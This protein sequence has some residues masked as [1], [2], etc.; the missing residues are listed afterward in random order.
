[1]DSGIITT[2]IPADETVVLMIV[3]GIVGALAMVYKTYKHLTLKKLIPM[4]I[5][6]II[7]SVIGVKILTIIP[8]KELKII[9]GSF[10]VVSAIVLATGYRVNLKNEKLSYSIAGFIGGITNGAI[11]F[12]GPPTV[13]FLQNQNEEKNVF[14]ANLS[15]YFLIIALTGSINLLL[16]GMLTKQLIIQAGV[17][18]VPVISGTILGNFLSHKINEKVF[19]KIVLGVLFAAGIMAIIFSII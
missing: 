15:L 12:G 4:L 11:S 5:L 7:G 10:I 2:F 17:L 13:L 6:G 8:V 14:R 1:M 3:I 19:R 9:M 18:I 16:N